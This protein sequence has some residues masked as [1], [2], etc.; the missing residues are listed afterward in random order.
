MEENWVNNGIGNGVEG[1][2]DGDHG[3]KEEMDGMGVT[4]CLKV[5]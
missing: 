4:Y 3:V 5:A 1:G 2:E